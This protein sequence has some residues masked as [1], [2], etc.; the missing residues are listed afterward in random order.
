MTRSYF[1]FRMS[2]NSSFFPAPYSRLL[3]EYPDREGPLHPEERREESNRYSAPTSSAPWSRRL[4]RKE[5]GV[6]PAPLS[7]DCRR[8]HK[9]G[10]PTRLYRRLHNKGASRLNEISPSIRFRHT[11]ASSRNKCRGLGSGSYLYKGFGPRQ[12]PARTQKTK[13]TGA[14]CFAGPIYSERP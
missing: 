11:P 6:L 10:N 14:T 9:R 5:T 3:S 12:S 7:A 13:S 8:K 2:N 1:F 4:G